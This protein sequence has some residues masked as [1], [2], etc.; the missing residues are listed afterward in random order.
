MKLCQPYL[1]QMKSWLAFR[2][3]QEVFAFVAA[4]VFSNAQEL[5]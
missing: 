2:G 5:C 3:D 4:D 1:R